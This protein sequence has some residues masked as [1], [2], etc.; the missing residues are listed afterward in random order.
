[1][2]QTLSDLSYAS[3]EIYFI[4]KGL[5]NAAQY[6]KRITNTSQATYNATE[7]LN[8]YALKQRNPY[9]LTPYNG[10]KAVL[11]YATQ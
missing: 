3:M 1:M 2:D 11:T 6:I 9:L 10:V 7:L 5:K 4:Y 8:K